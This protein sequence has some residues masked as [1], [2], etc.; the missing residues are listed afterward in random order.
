MG[1]LRG[2]GPTGVYDPVV[3]PKARF[4]RYFDFFSG[5]SGPIELSSQLRNQ[6]SPSTKVWNMGPIGPLQVEISGS[7]LPGGG[8]L[9]PSPSPRPPHPATP[10]EAPPEGIPE[11]PRK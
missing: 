2:G 5:C 7:T 4:W 11:G 9:G 3:L 8:G 10:G 6:V 1:P